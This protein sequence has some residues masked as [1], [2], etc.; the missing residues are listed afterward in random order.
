MH[1]IIIRR[2]ESFD[3]LLYDG[4]NATEVARFTESPITVGSDGAVEF[5]DTDGDKVTANI[6]EYILR[7]EYGNVVNFALSGDSI[8][9]TNWV[10]GRRRERRTGAASAD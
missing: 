3:A 2:Q 7:D 1:T 9:G 4:K 10:R 6:G 5:Q 8:D